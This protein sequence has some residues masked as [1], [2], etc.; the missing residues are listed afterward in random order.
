MARPALLS[1]IK[2][3]DHTLDHRIVLAPL[4]RLRNTEQGVPQDHC[5]EY[6]EQRTTKNGLLISEATVISPVT[7]GYKFAPGIYTDQQI[8]GWKRV[9]DAVHAKGGV[10]YLQLW[11]L[12]RAVS[13]KDLPPGNYPV[14]ASAIAISGTG[15]FGTE[16]E[17][18]HALTIDEI[19]DT[20]RDYATAA[21]N[22]IKAGFDGVEIHGAHGYLIDQF[23]NTSSNV[24][25]DEYGGSIENRARFALEVVDA[26]VEAVGI[27]RVAIRFSPWCDFQDMKDDTPL[28]TWSYLT[29]Q[30]QAKHPGL[31]YIHFSVPWQLEI[32]EFVYQDN[33]SSSL[34]PFRKIWK[35]PF[36]ATGGFLESKTAIQH[37]E[38][39]PNDLIG[40]GRTFIANPDLVERVR[41]GWPF[42]KYNRSTF[43]IQGIEGY[44]D[45]PFY[46]PTL[47]DESGK[48]VAT[49]KTNPA[50]TSQL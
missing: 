30:L 36:I 14:S 21:K 5:I 10:I 26:V 29:E 25:T 42:N 35:G 43:Y 24:R 18:P 7:D 31:A 3:G 41:H 16:Y 45:Y 40:F 13:S 15:V 27:N 23:I 12:G 9:V 34:D 39:F 37:C 50:P 46:S 11:H 6:Y 20:I 4:T 48:P 1:P 38:K 19:Q 28:E 17:V 33:I 22:S 8:E 49:D 2:I 44:T 47:F 32:G